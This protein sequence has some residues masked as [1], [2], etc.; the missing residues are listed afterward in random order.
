MPE[1]RSAEE[2]LTAWEADSS[3]DSS[4]GLPP[5]AR[6]SE[7]FLPSGRSVPFAS[8]ISDIAK[9]VSEKRISVQSVRGE[10]SLKHLGRAINDADVDLV[11]TYQTIASFT[12]ITTEP[13]Y[14]VWGAL[15]FYHTLNGLATGTV[16]IAE[17]SGTVSMGGETGASV[18][19][20][21]YKFTA[22]VSGELTDQTPGTKTFAIQAKAGTSNTRVDATD[23][24]VMGYEYGRPPG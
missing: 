5:V 15:T 10:G 13:N 19:G 1:D 12:V 21:F 17:T 6:F 16:R 9:Q 3:E 2:G 7:D 22:S 14:V 23:A 11:T 24:W 8:S 18:A 4:T 20:A